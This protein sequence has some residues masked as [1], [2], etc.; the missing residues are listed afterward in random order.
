MSKSTDSTDQTTI[1]SYTA[2]LHFWEL[3]KNDNILKFETLYFTRM[4]VMKQIREKIRDINILISSTKT[5]LFGEN[6]QLLSTRLDN[7]SRFLQS[8][9]NNSCSLNFITY[10]E[11]LNM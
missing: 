3:L 7:A 11:T 8:I 6:E 10:S 2:I 9:N 1:Y 4:R 5:S